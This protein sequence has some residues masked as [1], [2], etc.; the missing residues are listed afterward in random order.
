[1]TRGR[2]S[3]IGLVAVLVCTFLLLALT[4]KA[5]FRGLGEYLVESAPAEKS[6]AVVVLA[7]DPR[8]NRV[9]R[10]GELVRDGYAPV[11][12][13]SGPYDIYGVNEAD[14]AIQFAV[15]RGVPARYFERVDTHSFST[16]Q[17]ARA[18]LPELRKRDVR[19]LLL[20]TSNFHTRRAAETFRN[21]LGDGVVVRSITAPDPFFT[22][23]TWWHNRE[24]QKTVFYE[25]SKTLAYWAGL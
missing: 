12:L 7:G 24:G 5:V 1:L 4:H 10:A 25:Y 19:T 13:V 21:V 15:R 14:L 9:M 20:V 3:A 23:S 2:R 22:T 6:D 17:E 8:G 11:A 16:E 18:F